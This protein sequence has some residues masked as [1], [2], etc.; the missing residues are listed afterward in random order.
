MIDNRSLEK[1]V[2]DT[3]NDYF[4][5]YNVH[6]FRV[7]IIIT[8]S[9]SAAYYRVRPDLGRRDDANDY[10]GVM[11]Q[12]KHR[13]EEF[14]ILINQSTLIGNILHGHPATL[15]TII[16]EL[17]HINDFKIYAD[18]IDEVDYDVIADP[19][20]HPMFMLWTEIHARANGYYYTRWYQ[21]KEKFGSKE[22]VEM[23]LENELPFQNSYLVENY[24]KSESWYQR[25]Y[26][27]A[28][29][30]GRLYTI[31]KAYRAAISE[32]L[33]LSVTPLPNNQWIKEWFE[34]FCSHDSLETAFPSF[35][36]MRRII[37][38]QLPNLWI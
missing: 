18:M 10:N 35:D 17:T 7:S 38:A 24:N 26:L 8:K 9:I 27:V 31:R 2:A 16:H 1:L 13:G 15:G 33:L 20:K 21:L 28:Q 14:T 32:D 34:Y 36:E 25:A 4:K 12:P 30:I 22:Y 23:V 5:L 29:Y 3:I 6:P 37:P 11:V 19:V